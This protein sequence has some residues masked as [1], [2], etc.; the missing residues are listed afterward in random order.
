MDNKVRLNASIFNYLYN[1]Q[2]VSVFE[3]VAIGGRIKN[4]GRTDVTG[5]GLDGEAALTK[6]DRV[7][8]T[9]NYLNAAFA[10][11]KL[12]RNR[13]GVGVLMQQA[14]AQY[15]RLN[16]RLLRVMTMIL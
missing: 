6:A 3:N 15:N 2:Q 14:I 13:V 4:A 7:K 8:F 12:A 5:V 1:N 11:F 9:I 10:N 16:G